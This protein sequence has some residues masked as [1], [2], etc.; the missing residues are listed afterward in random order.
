MRASQR[1]PKLNFV[2]AGVKLKDRRFKKLNISKRENLFLLPSITE[3]EKAWLYR[4]ACALL[5]LSRSEGFDLPVLEA[6]H[7]KCPVLLSDIPVHHE[8]YKE[9]EWVKTE[10]D[11]WKSLYLAK[12]ANL[13][14]PTPRGTYTWE[15]AA[16]R[17]LL[18]F[19]RVLLNKDR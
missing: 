19:L 7:A 17:S 15:K 3:A 14:V 6:V 4:N 10:E 1:F 8:L 16:Q 5:A 9:A 12:N 13:K 11:L 18:F 2:I